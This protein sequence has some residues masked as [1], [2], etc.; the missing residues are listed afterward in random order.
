MISLLRPTTYR[1]LNRHHTLIIT[2][3]G[4]LQRIAQ[5]LS[6]LPLGTTINRVPCKDFSKQV[7]DKALRG[8]PQ[9][10]VSQFH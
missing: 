6:L 10:V 2:G 9:P 7:V 8:F 3:L 4:V 1:S 5:S